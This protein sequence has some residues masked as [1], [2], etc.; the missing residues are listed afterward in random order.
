MFT[1]LS[2]KKKEIKKSRWIEQINKYLLEL[3]KL[4]KDY[5]QKK[6]N[7]NN[8]DMFHYLKD[9]NLDLNDNDN[10]NKKNNYLSI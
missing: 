9:N 1:V 6:D 4:W 8:N 3:E 2:Q 7:N 5:F 10:D